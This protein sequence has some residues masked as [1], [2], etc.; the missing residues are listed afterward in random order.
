MSRPSGS[1]NKGVATRSGGG[2]FKQADILK[3]RCM[4]GITNLSITCDRFIFAGSVANS[5]VDQI[6]IISQLGHHEEEPSGVD[7]RRRQGVFHGGTTGLKRN[8]CST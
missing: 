1:V 7:D 2:A 4:A 6:T 5:M 8:A 3:D